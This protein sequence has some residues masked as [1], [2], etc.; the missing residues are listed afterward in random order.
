MA[1]PRKSPSPQ[2]AN[3]NKNKAVAMKQKK[4]LEFA[5]HQQ[6]SSQL[7]F[8]T[9]KFCNLIQAS[10]TGTID[11]SEASIQLQVPKRRVYDI[12]NVLEGVGLVEKR[13]RNMIVWTGGSLDPAISSTGASPLL[14]PLSKARVGR[15]KMV[16]KDAV[17][18]VRAKVDHYYRE[19]AMLDSW[20]SN[21]TSQLERQ[22]QK[23]A[24]HRIQKPN[25]EP[26]GR[27]MP[28]NFVFSTDIIEALYYPVQPEGSDHEDGASVERKKA[29][30]T[31]QSSIIAV[32]APE[33]SVSE[34]SAAVQDGK[35]KYRLSIAE[36]TDLEKIRDELKRK[37]QENGEHSS[38]PRKS[39]HKRQRIT[40]SPPD[41]ETDGDGPI[42]VYLMPVEANITQTK[43]ISAG[44]KLLPTDPATLEAESSTNNANS[45]E[46]SDE[47]A[48]G[49]DEQ[50]RDWNYA[51]N[52]LDADEGAANFF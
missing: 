19:E 43:M 28:L 41:R 20:I 47:V 39:P 14:S 29:Q 13:S 40:P 33:G 9:R 22:K 5:E 31:P 3:S 15:T 26:N 44:T 21:L 12:V 48:G 32:H 52:T 37:A 1:K 24:Q 25:G 16:A 2:K 36:K 34:V 6:E 38:T 51:T 30:A 46:P 7:G 10:I 17:E 42:Q 27:K 23:A 35:T 45:G 8:L 18:K 4:E 11:L 50:G 49:G